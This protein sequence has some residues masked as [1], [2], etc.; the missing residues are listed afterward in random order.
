MR[1]RRLSTRL[2]L[3]AV[4]I[5]IVMTL[6]SMFAVSWVI[7]Q[8]YLHQSHEL[9]VKASRLIDENLKERQN[10]QSIL[11]NYQHIDY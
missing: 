11:N 4:F 1:I 8:Q 7:S 9:L 5:G 2:L 10:N 3:G 6:T